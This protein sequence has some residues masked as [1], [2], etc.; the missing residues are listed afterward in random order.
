M[1]HPFKFVSATDVHV[2]H[3]CLLFRSHVSCKAK[4]LAKLVRSGIAW[5]LQIGSVSLCQTTALT[6]ASVYMTR[7]P[8]PLA[9]DEI[10]KIRPC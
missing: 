10:A 4:Q 1:T 7:P 9:R 5:L 6:C 3:T 2:L 8:P